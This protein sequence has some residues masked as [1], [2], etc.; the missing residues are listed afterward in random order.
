[1][2]LQVICIIECMQVEKSSDDTVKLKILQTALTMLQNP[3]NADDQVIQQQTTRNNA[4]L[5]YQ[6]N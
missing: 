4:Q 2:P 1:M 3:D 6:Q 5:L